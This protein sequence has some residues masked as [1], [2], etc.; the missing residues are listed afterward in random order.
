MKRLPAI[1]RIRLSAIPP[2]RAAA[3]L[4]AVALLGMDPAPAAARNFGSYGQLFP[5]EEPDIL[6]TILSRLR[7]AE[8]SGGLARMEEDFQGRA[9]AYIERP[10][11]G[12]ALP[13]AEEYRAFEF[14]PSITVERDLADHRGVIF[15]R[16]GSRVNPLDYSAFS[17]RIVVIDGDE[18]AQVA[19]ALAEGNELDTLIVIARGAPLELGRQHGRRFWVDQQNVILG[20]FGVERVPTVITRQ[21]PNFLI[22]EIPLEETAR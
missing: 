2:F 8:A 11:G 15:A 3:V 5:V 14:D 17:K 4:A 13:P 16:A 19:F 1:P 20:R 21:D 6:E 9:R 10:S 18:P 12:V 7:T 22:E